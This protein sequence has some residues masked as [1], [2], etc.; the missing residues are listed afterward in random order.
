MN[1]PFL[2]IDFYPSIELNVQKGYN[3]QS[4]TFSPPPDQSAAGR[5]C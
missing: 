1:P 4:F 2:L 5:L 3:L